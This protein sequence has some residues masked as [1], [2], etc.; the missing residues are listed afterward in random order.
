MVNDG[1]RDLTAAYGNYFLK[2]PD[3]A[4]SQRFLSNPDRVNGFVAKTTQEAIEEAKATAAGKIRYMGNCGFDGN[5]AVGR[6]LEFNSNVDSNQSGFV[7]AVPSTLRELSL[8]VQTAATATFTVVKWNGSVETN[9]ATISV[10]S[11]RT[12]VVTGLTVNLVALDELRVKLT[13]GS[14]AR[15]ICF[16]FYQVI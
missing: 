13:A 6:Y 4:F 9:L 11:T 7:I 1:L 8:A 15:P 14:C 2:Y 12:S 3:E 10:T 16:Q 5:A